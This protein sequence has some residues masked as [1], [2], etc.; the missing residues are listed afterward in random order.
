LE[1][2]GSKPT[3]ANSSARPYLKE[4]FSKIGLMEWLKVTAMSPSPNTTTKKKFVE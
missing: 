3:Q 4:P 2:H 1:D